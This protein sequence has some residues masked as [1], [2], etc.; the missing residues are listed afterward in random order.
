M[1]SAE[2]KDENTVIFIEKTSDTIINLIKDS[3]KFA[4]KREE[5]L[6]YLHKNSLYCKDLIEK[7]EYK[8]CLFILIKLNDVCLKSILY[9]PK[10]TNEEL[11][12]ILE[13]LQD[14]IVNSEKTKD[15]ALKIDTSVMIKNMKYFEKQSNNHN[16]MIKYYGIIG[17]FYFEV[18]N[19][20][21]DIINNIGVIYH[22]RKKIDRALYYMNLCS[23]IMIKM[24]IYTLPQ[25]FKYAEIALNLILSM[26][27][28]SNIENIGQAFC[29]I[30]MFIENLESKVEQIPDFIQSYKDIQNISATLIDLVE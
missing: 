25:L 29:N 14:L 13:D 27:D 8:N 11:K 12:A 26:S 6:D 28:E 1:I 10:E 9:K 7:K 3:N 2:E 16:R 19:I 5:I 18:L 24:K 30:I 20:L 15:K 21:I 17:E 4:D 23:N 22:K